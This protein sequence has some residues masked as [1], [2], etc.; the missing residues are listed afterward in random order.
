MNSIQEDK[1]YIASV[2]KG[3][4]IKTIDYMRKILS[5]AYCAECEEELFEYRPTNPYMKTAFMTL[6]SLECIQINGTKYGNT[7]YGITNPGDFSIYLWKQRGN[8]RV[9]LRGFHD[10]NNNMG[11]YGYPGL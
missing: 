11:M 10:R 3:V 9:H 1:E 7:V 2:M 8:R 6:I 5:M 4:N